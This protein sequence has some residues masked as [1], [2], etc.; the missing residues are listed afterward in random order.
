LRRL[1]LPMKR[2]R[3]QPMPLCA[4]AAVAVHRRRRRDID[5]SQPHAA[6]PRCRRANIAT[7]PRH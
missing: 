3:R 5:C 4:A 7:P 6:T 1:L 2:R